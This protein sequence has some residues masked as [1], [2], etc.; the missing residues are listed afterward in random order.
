M[1]TTQD[2]RPIQLLTL[3]EYLR[4]DDGTETRYELVDGV[5]T[6]MPTENPL[7]NT[8]ILFL[9]SALLKV[10]VPY[11]HLATNHQIQVNSRK[12]SA[13]Q[14]DLVV[15]T[16]ASASAILRDGKL[17]R[18]HQP[19][20]DLVVEVVSSSD[21]DQRSRDRDYLEK[22]QEY[23]QQGIAEYWIIDP[24]A[25]VVLILTWVDETYQESVYTGDDL[26]ASSKF[27]ALSSSAI[28]LLTAGLP[29]FR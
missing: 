5:L 8:I 14:P 13:R 4:Y 27:P 2:Q 22:R 15:H 24:I 16:P 3:E 28:E 9:I 19:A 11:Y 20:P 12:V 26:L 1:A 17:L 25:A 23:A 18:L 21:S 6:A 29:K 7:N 10:G